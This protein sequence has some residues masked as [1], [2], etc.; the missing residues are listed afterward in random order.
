MASSGRSRDIA[1]AYKE[2]M[3]LLLRPAPLLTLAGLAL[4][5]TASLATAPFGL[6]L[7]A[8]LLS[9]TFKYSIA[10]LD[11]LTSGAKA[12]PVLSVGMIL[13]SLRDWRLTITLGLAAV[14]FFIV[15]GSMEFYGRALL[16][17]LAAATPIALPAVL[18]VHAWTHS[19]E[20][21][22]RPTLALGVARLLGNDYLRLAGVT[23]ALIVVIAFV[24]T[25]IP[26]LLVHVA[27][28]LACWFVLV[29]HVGQVIAARR[30]D[31]EE[32]TLFEPPLDL[33]DA[34][35]KLAAARE[36]AADEIYA[37]WRSGATKQAWTAV[38]RHVRGARHPAEE[39]YWL[40][41]R[42]SHWDAKALEERIAAAL[43][44][45]LNS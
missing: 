21:A 41:R 8:I 5:I 22:F 3:A 6:A 24:A 12:M 44:D 15:A 27:A 18:V 20:Q 30:A 19:A 1:L 32:A 11:A 16:V 42:V 23:A 25:R 13:G 28:D 7:L 36:R 26:S 10:L 31:L 34:G 40:Q 9:W 2:D 29:V 37:H 43:R 45:T 33:T 39:L 14:L 4:A 17:L 38:E 35:E